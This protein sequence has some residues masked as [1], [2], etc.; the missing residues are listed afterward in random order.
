M[1]HP[2]AWNFSR[3]VWAR[4]TK[5]YLLGGNRLHETTGYDITSYF[6]SAA[7]CKMQSNTLQTCVRRERPAKESNNSITFNLKLSNFAYTSMPTQCTYA[8]DMTSTVASD[9][10]LSKFEKR[11]KMPHPTALGSLYEQWF[12]RGSRNFTHLSETIGPTN[13]PDMTSLA[14][15]CRLQ[16]QLN[17]AQKC[18]KLVRPARVK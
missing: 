13:L 12:K 3:T 7:K 2:L 8:S 11:R 9:R 10:Q 5:F 6:W 15:T 1:P 17:T 18:V 16:M 4:I 14:A